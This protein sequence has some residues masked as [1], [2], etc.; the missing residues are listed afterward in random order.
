[1]SRVIKGSVPLPAASGGWPELPLRRG[2]GRREEAPPRRSC[3]ADGEAARQEEYRAGYEE[4]HRRG[5]EEGL[6]EGRGQAEAVLREA[7][8]RLRQVE[9]ARADLE[10]TLEEERARLLEEV[11]EDVA[12]LAMAVARRVL[13]REL[14]VSAEDVLALVDR[15][16]EEARGREG[17]RVRVHPRDGFAL[18]AQREALAARAGGPL[19][20]VGDATLS[21]GDAVIETAGGTWDARLETRLAG[22]EQGLRAGLGLGGE[23]A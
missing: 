8:E 15:L 3:P 5:Y 1:L 20:I 12:R 6:A 18:E 2:A 23:Q 21:P 4:G 9:A 22:A 13:E 19:E 10:R 17:V 14:T 11:R 7:E 16:L